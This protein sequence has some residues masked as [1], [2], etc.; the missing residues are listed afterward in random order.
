MLDS[1]DMHNKYGI[2]NM[3]L[4]LYFA[5]YI[6]QDVSGLHCSTELTTFGS[7]MQIDPLDSFHQYYAD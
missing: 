5:E 4:T 7:V 2:S 1:T 6:S 3:S